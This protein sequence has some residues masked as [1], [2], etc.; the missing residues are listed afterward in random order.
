MAVSFIAINCIIVSVLTFM[1]TALAVVTNNY[2]K[3][4]PV[5]VLLSAALFFVGK[6]L[7][8]VKMRKR[9]DAYWLNKK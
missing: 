7:L 4:F 1:L 6:L 9:I 5:A 2:D 8:S 3:W